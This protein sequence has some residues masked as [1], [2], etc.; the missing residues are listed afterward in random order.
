MQHAALYELPLTIFREGKFFV[1]YTP[2]L[3]I[4]SAGETQEEAYNMFLEAVEAFF[5]ELTD[6]GA[7]DSTLQDLGWTKTQDSYLP[8]EVVQQSVIG[9][10]VP[11]LAH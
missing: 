9:I 2:A 11:R 5:E 7:L 4:S 8:P 10:R 3:D 1:A 6:A